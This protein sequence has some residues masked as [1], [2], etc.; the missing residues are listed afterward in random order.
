MSIFTNLIELPFGV[1]AWVLWSLDPQTHFRH[2]DGQAP[3]AGPAGTAGP[4]AQ[5]AEPSKR[6]T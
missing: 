2:T 1:L 6:R 4:S 5:D 3:P